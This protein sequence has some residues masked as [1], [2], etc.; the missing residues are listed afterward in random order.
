MIRYR[1]YKNIRAFMM[2][3]LWRS[4]CCPLC[5][6]HCYL[7]C[8]RWL[9]LSSLI[10]AWKLKW[11]YCCSFSA[12]LAKCSIFAP[13]FFCT[14]FSPYWQ[15][16]SFSDSNKCEI[17]EGTLWEKEMWWDAATSHYLW[18]SKLLPWKSS[19]EHFTVFT[20]TNSKTLKK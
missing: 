7:L 11:F 1:F 19:I 2:L 16:L 15:C 17:G 10:P 8:T 13:L 12:P 18:S 4:L 9:L 5:L 14:F 6:D 20:P 3:L